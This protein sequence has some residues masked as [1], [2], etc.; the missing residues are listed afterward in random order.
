[1][2][3]DELH[4]MGKELEIWLRM[5]V[6]PIA[7]KVSNSKNEVPQGVIIPTRDGNINMPYVRLLLDPRMVMKKPLP[8][9]RKIIGV[10][11]QSLVLV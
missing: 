3:L 7:V 4:Q 8:C 6:H 2:N 10:L 5:R 11:N 9:L 1:M